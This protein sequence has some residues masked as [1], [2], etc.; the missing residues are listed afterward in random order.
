MAIKN[1]EQMIEILSNDCAARGHYIIPETGETCAI[2]ALLKET[3]FDMEY[4]NRP[5]RTKGSSRYHDRNSQAVWALP[6]VLQHLKKQFG[7]TE[8]EARKI[9]TG[10]DSSYDQNSRRD[11]VI[12]I[13]NELA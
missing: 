7:L 10:N 6:K 3:D 12:E 13:V 9:Q 5:P 1:K 2:G 4:F 8:A 11:K